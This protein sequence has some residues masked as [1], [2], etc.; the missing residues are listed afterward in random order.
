MG[1]RQAQVNW[2]GFEGTVTINEPVLRY[3]GNPILTCH[4]VNEIWGNDAR[5]YTYTVHNA[6]MAEVTG[7]HGQKQIIMLFRSHIADGRSLIGKAVSDNGL[8]GWKVD[9]QPFLLPATGNDLFAAGIDIASIIESEAGGVEDVRVNPVGGGWYVLTYSAYHEE[10]T[11]RVKAMVAVTKDF[12][13]IVR[14]GFISKQDMRNVVIFPEPDNNTWLALL[15]PNDKNRENLGFGH[16]G[17]LFTE[18]YT[19]LA[20]S[21]TGPW[22]IGKVIMRSGHGPGAFQVK[23]GPGAPPIKT[24]YGWLNVFHGVRSTMDGNPYTLGVAFHDLDDPLNPKKLRISAKPLLMPGASDCVVRKTDYV[25]VPNVVF[26]CGALIGGDD[27]V[28][29]YYGGNDTVMNVGLANIQILDEMCS[30]FPL[31]PLTGKHLYSL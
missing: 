30:I 7:V 16:I 3:P 6:G 4:D 29:I 31:H 5:L 28:A 2:N 11:D 25:H 20:P 27:T 9:P 1:C 10:I 24:R 8:D 14:Y 22:E 19:G 13:E 15:R 26:S 18:I 17:G 23:I 21:P 12:K